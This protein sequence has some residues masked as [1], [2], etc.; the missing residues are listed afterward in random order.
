M[1]LSSKRF[2][3]NLLSIIDHYKKYPEMLPW[4]GCDYEKESFKLLLVGESHYLDKDITYHHNASAW[5]G[6]LTLPDKDKNWIYTRKVISIGIEQNWKSKPKT[7][8]RNA[9]KALME[10]RYYSDD[11]TA[12][13]KLAFT[14]YFQRPAEHTGKSIK[15]SKIDQEASSRVFNA[16]VEI[17]TP[18]AVVFISSLAYKEAKAGGVLSHLDLLS[19][20]FL[21][22][23]HPATAWW[24]RNSKAYGNKSGRDHMISFID[25]LYR[26]TSNANKA[27]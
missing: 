23:S 8:Y 11:K 16:V 2:D 24:Y 12:F 6:G 21:R 19:I 15:A 10:T 14:N 3:E 1:D 26:L 13:T 20:P 22:T 5:Y 17:L 4:V 25:R 27:N 18:D 9:D 7:I